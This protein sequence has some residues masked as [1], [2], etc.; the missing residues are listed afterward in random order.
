M[1]YIDIGA[2]RA[3]RAPLIAWGEGR[4][5]SPRPRLAATLAAAL[6]CTMAAWIALRFHPAG[7]GGGGMDDQRYLDF[8]NRWWSGY[9]A[10]GNTHWALRH[11]LILSILAAFRLGGHAIAS[12]AYVPL[13]Y[14]LGLVALTAAM[15]H[16][17]VSWRAAWLWTALFAAS[18]VLHEMA[19]SLFP[20][21]LELAFGA[22]S[23]WLVWDALS[24]SSLRR[25]K[26]A[27]AG[28]CLALAVL[29]RETAAALALFYAGFFLFRPVVPRRA[30]LWMATGFLPVIA[31]D[32]GWI[33]SETGDWLYRWHVGERHVLIASEHLVGKVY[34]GGS[35]LLNFDL[36]S[37]WVPSGP[38]P[39]HWTI[40]PVVNLLID[41]DFGFV[42]LGWAILSLPWFRKAAGRLPPFTAALLPLAIVTFL[43]VTWV[44]VLRPQPRYYLFAVYAAT[45]MVA[46][47]CDRLLAMRARRRAT[48]ALLALLL[49]VGSVAILLQRDLGRPAALVIPYLRTHAGSYYVEDKIAARLRS[50]LAE[51]GLE[52]RIRAGEPPVG[53]IRI[54]VL[55]TDKPFRM[56]KTYDPAPGYVLVERTREGRPLIHRLLEQPLEPQRPALLVERRVR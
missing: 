16:R 38:F 56:G 40:D 12:L 19:T 14:A 44:L 37:R 9:V 49:L 6:L 7:F 24:T 8:A 33:W 18:P 53:A 32:I 47:R 50:P 21:I 11:P 30:W 28:A 1:T 29:T 34:R 41:P 15:L 25:L 39:L 23:L 4:G 52:A 22:A 17:H 48:A 5:V 51:A 13:A 45:I 20:E 10:P 55:P 46:V 26:M 27:A 43:F 42:F 3:G 35:P 31:A 36:A 2:G 54:R